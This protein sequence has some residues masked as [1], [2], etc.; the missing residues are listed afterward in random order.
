[1][2]ERAP[3][4]FSFSCSYFYHLFIRDF[5]AC[6]SSENQ[7]D[8]TGI[9]LSAA[10]YMV[11]SQIEFEEEIL[12]SIQCLASFALPV[13]AVAFQQPDYLRP[14]MFQIFLTLLFAE[15]IEYII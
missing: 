1:M 13:L 12:G 2:Q 6:P 9:A 8:D 4:V 7:T 10:F 5:P 15:N 14:D 11:A 3:I